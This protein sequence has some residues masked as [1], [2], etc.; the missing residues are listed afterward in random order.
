MPLFES[1]FVKALYAA[2]TGSPAMPHACPSLAA[3]DIAASSRGPPRG[4]ELAESSD[5][6]AYWLGPLFEHLGWEY[7]DA[8]EHEQALDAFERA[9]EVRLRDPE[10]AAA[11]EHGARGGRRGAQGARPRQ[12]TVCYLARP[13]P[14]RRLPSPRTVCY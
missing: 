8:G 11:I 6:A 14:R 3:P 9:L 12:V 7:F 10:N 13:A 4:I 5:A 1:A 2:R